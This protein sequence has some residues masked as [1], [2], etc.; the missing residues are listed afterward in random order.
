MAD[1]P[2]LQGGLRWRDRSPD[3]YRPPMT[4]D[5]RSFAPILDTIFREIVF[6]SPDPGTRT[7]LLNRGDA[8]LLASLDRLSAGEASA[9]HGGGASI[10]AHVDH[11]RYGSSLLNAWATGT[12]PPVASMDWTASWR[13]NVVS[14]EEWRKLRDELRREA[15]G[16]A[17][18]LRTPR[19]VSEVEAGWLIGSIAH[20]AYHM[21]AIRQIDRATR[22]PTAED[23]GR[24][25][26][27]L[28][29]SSGEPSR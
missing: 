29:K 12:L 15:E 9:R 3:V 17:E 27:E 8:G 16:W 28:R 14:D 20:I 11:L 5:S 26:V 19:E 21:G 13:R 18:T 6:G 25:E 22:G 7:Y 23:E 24:A 1:G 10:A 2:G 4:I